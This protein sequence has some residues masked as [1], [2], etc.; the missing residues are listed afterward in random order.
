MTRGLRRATCAV[1]ALVLVGVTTGCTTTAT[2]NTETPAEP[3][4]DDDWVVLTFAETDQQFDVD[5]MDALL[6]YELAADDALAAA[7]AGGIDGNDVGDYQYTVYFVG[8]DRDVIWR[9]LEPIFADAP[10]PWTRVELREE[11]EDE[12]PDVITQ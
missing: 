4:P 6:E 9:L 11:F 8:A 3:D 10:I 2:A 12:S 7:G 1:F 5:V